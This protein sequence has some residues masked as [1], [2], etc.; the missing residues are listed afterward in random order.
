[1]LYDVASN[2][3]KAL[4]DGEMVDQIDA[5]AAAAVAADD[6]AIDAAAA[7]DDAADA[8]TAADDAGLAATTGAS[9][10]ASAAVAAA[11]GAWQILLNTSCDAVECR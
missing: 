10:P 6:N 9:R 2:I 11:G 5:G 4:L 7:D 8:A 1:M 3:P